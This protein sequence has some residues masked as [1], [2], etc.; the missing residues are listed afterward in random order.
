MLC[1]NVQIEHAT[2]AFNVFGPAELIELNEES[3]QTAGRGIL[4][5][6]AAGWAYG[7][8]TRPQMTNTHF[9]G[10]GSSSSKLVMQRLLNTA[11]AKIAYRVYLRES[12]GTAQLTHPTGG[13]SSTFTQGNYMDAELAAD[14]SF[15]QYAGPFA[16]DEN[17]PPAGSENLLD[18]L[19]AER[20]ARNLP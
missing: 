7:Y 19:D 18:T 2:G 5:G 4:G 17:N 8:G 9:V 10:A 12:S 1:K 20:A 16:F 13:N 11:T 3:S 6:N 14:G 15:V